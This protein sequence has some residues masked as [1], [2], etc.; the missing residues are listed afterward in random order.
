[1]GHVSQRSKIDVC[2]E[3]RV[4]M[5]KI[6]WKSGKEVT[7]VKNGQFKIWKRTSKNGSKCQK[8]FWRE[9]AGTGC[10][11]SSKSE[12]V[13]TKKWQNRRNA[14]IGFWKVLKGPK[15]TCRNLVLSS[16][17]LGQES[18]GRCPKWVQK[19]KSGVQNRIWEIGI[20]VGVL[21]MAKSSKWRFWVSKVEVKSKSGQVPCP[22]KSSLCRNGMSKVHDQNTKIT[23]KFDDKIGSWKWQNKWQINRVL[24]RSQTSSKP[25]RPGHR[26][27]TW[28]YTNVH[29]MK[30]GCPEMSKLGPKSTKLMT[31]SDKMGVRFQRGFK[32]QHRQI[33]TCK[34]QGHEINVK[35]TKIK[36]QNH[37]MP[38]RR[39]Q[40]WK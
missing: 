2:Y 31:K 38:N 35:I 19:S 32:H 16:V 37:D 14:K 36:H 6:S 20:Q 17:R 18:S 40:N 13:G 23:W 5:I 22:G 9:K 33:T 34:T 25:K 1:M 39:S 3:G 4:S 12:N 10:Q 27:R 28:K 30:T 24:E 7:F 21:K 29:N 11:K 15:A 8:S 26:R